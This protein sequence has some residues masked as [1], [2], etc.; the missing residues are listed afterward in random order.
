MLGICLI[1]LGIIVF[2]YEVK[3]SFGLILLIIAVYV[4]YAWLADKV[5]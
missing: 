2:L 3:F 5:N 4:L 1:V